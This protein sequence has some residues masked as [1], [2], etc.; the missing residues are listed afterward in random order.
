MR[1]FFG[2]RACFDSW[3]VE[4]GPAVSALTLKRRKQRLVT[5]LAKLEYSVQLTRILAR[6]GS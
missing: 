6:A 2:C 1:P 5:Q 4:Y 3:R